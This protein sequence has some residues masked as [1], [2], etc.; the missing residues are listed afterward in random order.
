MT[1]VPNTMSPILACPPLV[2][3]RP[4]APGRSFGLL[5]SSF[6]VAGDWPAPVLITAGHVATT[7]LGSGGFCAA[8]LAPLGAY[9][10]MTLAKVT[11]WHIRTDLDLAVGTFTG[12][13]IQGLHL[14]SGVLSGNADLATYEHSGSISTDSEE[15]EIAR[16]TP[17]LRKGHAVQRR[18]GL[19]LFYPTIDMLELSYPALKGASGAPVFTEQ[20]LA[21]VG[22]VVA[23]VER[24]LLPAQVLR[25]V[26]ET[27]E[28]QEEVLYFLPNALAVGPP[29]L[30]EIVAEAG[31]IL[32]TDS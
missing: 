8:A 29:S 10:E 14:H 17:L 3:G 11:R 6:I 1:V 23:N 28:L 16:V 27:G 4:T 22:V 24:E 20:G 15:P 30:E 21:V 9:G 2:M 18:R 5:G 7:D 25:S 26:T 19:R 31:D 13:N 12:E 32:F